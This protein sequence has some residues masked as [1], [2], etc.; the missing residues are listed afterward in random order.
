MK[1]SEK[2]CEMC[3]KIYIGITTQKYCI[4]CRAIRKKQLNEYHNRKVKAEAAENKRKLK[5]H[6]TESSQTLSAICRL[7]KSKGLSYGQ[8][9]AR[10][11]A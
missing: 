2:K 8:Y 11:Y 5:E 7:A 3:G 1:S 4:D 6:T 9:V 10:Y